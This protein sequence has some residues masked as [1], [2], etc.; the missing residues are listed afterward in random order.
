[1]SYESLKGMHTRIFKECKVPGGQPY[2]IRKSAVKWASRCGARKY[3]IRSVSRHTESANFMKCIEE[4][5]S[6]A[7]QY[8]NGS[9]KD[10]IRTIWVFHPCTWVNWVI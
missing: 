6:I 1:M 9:Y 2:T 8:K 5:A 3:E 4:G 10:P 7:E